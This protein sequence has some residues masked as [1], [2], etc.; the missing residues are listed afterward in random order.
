M[1]AYFYSILALDIA[2]ERS[3]EAEQRWLA[4]SIAGASPS[5]A[6]GVRR[7]VAQLLAAVS[8][9]AASAVHRLDP[10]VADDLR[11]TLAPAE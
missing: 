11:R 7:V 3:L 8:R 5:A 2:R 4:R 9:G 10:R 6:S 1:N